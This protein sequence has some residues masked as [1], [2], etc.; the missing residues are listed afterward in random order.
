MTLSLN[1]KRFHAEALSSQSIAYMD[2]LRS[3]RLSVRLF[4]Q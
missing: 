4:M 1:Q 2:S 3:L